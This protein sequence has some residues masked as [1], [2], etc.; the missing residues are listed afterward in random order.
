MNRYQRFLLL[1]AALFLSLLSAFAQ[2]PLAPPNPYAATLDRLNEITALPLSGWTQ[3]PGDMAHG[4]IP[5]NAA[6]TM[7]AS[8]CKLGGSF[9]PPVWLYREIEI[10]KELRGY[11]LRGSTL[12]LDIHVGSN[13][14]LMITTFANGNMI[15]R[16]D[17]D[18]QVPITLTT[19]AQPADK[20]IVALRVLPS[21][22]V[23]CCGGP[24]QAKLAQAQLLITP[25]VNRPDP[26]VIRLELLSAQLLV[27]AYPRWQGRARADARCCSESHRHQG[28]RRL[29]SEDIRR[30][31][32]SIAGQARRAASLHEAVQ[33]QRH[34]QQ[35]HRHGLALAVDGDRRSRAQHLRHRAR[36]MNEYPDF[37]FTASTAQA[38]T[39]IEE[40]YPDMFTRSSSA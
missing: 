13:Q 37:K 16:T 35:P 3:V 40:K 15:A 27:A 10:P 28:S 4:E 36:L 29:R 19:N 17:E 34:R 9:T 14:G 11:E 6:M 21:A 5:P 20:I 32:A 12:K 23:G 26:A 18:G 38:Y 2:Q 22:G 30:L 1:F 33:H 25:P 7:N 39:W 31:A 8:E 24:L